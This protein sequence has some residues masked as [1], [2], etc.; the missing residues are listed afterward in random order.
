MRFLGL[1]DK[2]PETSVNPAGYWTNYN[3]RKFFDDYAQKNNFDPLCA[4]N[5]YNVKRKDV[6]MERVSQGNI[7]N[8]AENNCY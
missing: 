5:W 8:T 4:N 3:M 2:L 7:F 1:S 6:I